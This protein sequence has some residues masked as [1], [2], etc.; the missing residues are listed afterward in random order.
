[1][2]LSD[3]ASQYVR[4][5][6]LKDEIDRNI[7]EFAE[8]SWGLGL[9][10]SAELPP[11]SRFQKF[12]FKCYYNIPLDKKEKVII[13]RDKFNEQERFRFTEE[14]Y[15]SFL[16]NEGRIN[17][18][19]VTGNPKD[20]RKNLVLVI[21]RRGFKTSS[22]GIISSFETYKLLKKFSPQE[23][24]GIPA[25]DEIWI[26]CIAT[27]QDQACEL[28]RRIT[29]Q[30]ERSEYFRKFRNK[31]T[32]SYMQLST[33]RDI[34]RYG[35]SGRPSMRIVAAPCSGRGLRGHNNIVVIL[36][37]I[38]F[39]FESET[40]DDKSDTAIYEAV[41]PSVAKFTSPD[42]EPDGRIICISSPG[43]KSGKFWDL[44]QR[45][46][47]P[48]CS[49]LLMIQ[50]PTWEADPSISPK[51]LRDRYYENPVTYM[52]EYGAEFSDR[53]TGWIENEQILRVNI[54]PGLKEKRHSY[55][56]VPHFMGIDIGSKN[57]G[58]AIS[59]THP[60]RLI[61]NNAPKDF[62][63]LDCAE[64]R[65]AKDEGKTYFTP[66]ELADWIESFTKRFYIISGM[67]DQYFGL[68]I[69][70]ILEKRSIKQIKVQD[71]SR[72]LSS[73][74]FQNLMARLVDASLR[75][76]EGDERIKDGKR[77]KDSD[78][79]LELL[80]LKAVSHNKY[81][82]EVKAPEGK[83]FHDDLSDSFARSV[84]IASEYLLG[85]GGG[86]SLSQIPGSANTM[87]Y[88]KYY[89]KAKSAAIYTNRPS[90]SM[91]MDLSRNS[92]MNRQSLLSPGYTG[93]RRG[94]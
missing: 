17:I 42:G 9:G 24:Y 54:I 6:K 29:G 47:E 82:I 45:A 78:L 84:Y 64:V 75:I 40:S 15:L 50:A 46:M 31:P 90:S 23:Y 60:T 61:V 33:N 43:S 69:L 27:N 12:M 10:T 25:E 63:E 44:Y 18:K 7:I 68:P 11:L 86:L 19:E 8:S 92:M 5:P 93:R 28:F 26:T 55:E 57:D 94:F 13:V 72:D 62:I 21:G 16:W 81:V 52:S 83:N 58:S 30:L 80:Q 14:E 89:A 36:D 48:N 53:V 59:I 3:L 66:E 56:R 73:K 87:S 4:T 32:L 39:F 35:E 2:S 70:S 77:I 67:M 37:E 85:K 74:I 51:F 65:Y 22:C 38:A 88:K 91:L 1:M 71:M 20:T 79:I 49:N 41:T 76:T 34:E